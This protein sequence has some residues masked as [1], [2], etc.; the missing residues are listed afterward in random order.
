MWDFDNRGIVVDVIFPANPSHN[1]ASVISSTVRTY[2]ESQGLSN[3]FY[4]IRKHEITED[5][6]YLCK[7]YLIPTSLAYLVRIGT[8]ADFEQDVAY[9]YVDV[10]KFNLTIKH[11]EESEVL[12]KYI[13]L[14]FGRYVH[15]DNPAD[16]ESLIPGTCHK[17]GEYLNAV[18][19]GSVPVRELKERNNKK[20]GGLTNNVA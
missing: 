11:V 14:K 7:D 8:L 4:Y 19:F 6:T 17:V 3:S 12:R 18:L 10:E 16:M 5:V 9:H 1:L 2:Y 15:T 13:H 20:Q